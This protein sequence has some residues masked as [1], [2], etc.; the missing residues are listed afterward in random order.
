MAVCCPAEPELACAS[1][2]S[3]GATTSYNTT[4]LIIA[5]PDRST[6]DVLAFS[7]DPGIDCGPSNKNAEA[8]GKLWYAA[9]LV[10]LADCEWLDMNDLANAVAWKTKF[11]F[12]YI[13]VKIRD[14]F[15]CLE[16]E[17]SVTSISSYG[18]CW[19]SVGSAPRCQLSRS[20]PS[21]ITSTST[22]RGK[23]R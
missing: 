14:A 19:W 11:A 9:V 20:M 5:G 22:R 3:E 17:A 8:L 10:D 21:S 13:E 7:E 23:S 1:D 12:S 16:K 4:S 15:A 18:Y 2:D 6:A